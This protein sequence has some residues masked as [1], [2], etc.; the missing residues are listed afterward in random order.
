MY[1]HQSGSATRAALL[2]GIPGY[3]LGLQN[4]IDTGNNTSL[5]MHHV[6]SHANLQH[7]NVN[8]VNNVGNLNIVKS[9]YNSEIVSSA[10]S[11]HN[12]PP[13]MEQRLIQP[14]ISSNI[15][16]ISPQNELVYQ[17]RQISQES[18]KSNLSYH[19]HHSF[20][21]H[22]H[23]NSHSHSHSHS[24]KSLSIISNNNNNNN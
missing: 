8:N 13:K 21:S 5:I 3:E 22:S 6:G 14:Q 9:S 11:I 20:T 17:Q 19:S 24:P 16:S 2:T 15:T 1:A 7:L 4:G 23:S 18:I 12:T 10:Q